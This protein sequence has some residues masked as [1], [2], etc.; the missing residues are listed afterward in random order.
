M[1]P[2]S[3]GREGTPPRPAPLSCVRLRVGGPPRRPSSP[4]LSSTKRSSMP[5]LCPAYA[6]LCESSRRPAPARAGGPPRRPSAPRLSSTKRSS[7]PPLS[8]MYAGLC[9]SSGLPAPANAGGGLIRSS[10]KFSS[11]PPDQ[12]AWALPRAGPKVRPDLVP[13]RTE[14]RTGARRLQGNPWLPCTGTTRELQRAT[15]PTPSL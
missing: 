6:G 12:I 7:A 5:P 3:A 14:A 8:P 4:G 9:E 10:P 15:K 1:C 11:W 2:R 13:V